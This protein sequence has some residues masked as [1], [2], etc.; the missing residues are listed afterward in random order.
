MP[1]GGKR[2]A[3]QPRAQ[4]V[5]RT[6]QRAALALPRTNSPTWAC[7]SRRRYRSE[8]SFWARFA[9]RCR[10]FITAA[11]CFGVVGRQCRDNNTWELRTN[12]ARRTAT[13]RWHADSMPVLRLANRP[14]LARHVC[15]RQRRLRG[16]Q[17]RECTRQDAGWPGSHCR[18]QLA[19]DHHIRIAPAQ[20]ARAEQVQLLLSKSARSALSISSR[21]CS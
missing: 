5:K 3:T 19:V 1:E 9:V 16:G 11:C 18:H 8:Q 17:R 7:S 21:L 4:R 2:P 10:S 12:R 20:L 15:P 6:S 13:A 14:H